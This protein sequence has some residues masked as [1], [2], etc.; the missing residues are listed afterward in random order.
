VFGAEQFG[1]F[2]SHEVLRRISEMFDGRGIRELDETEIIDREND[3]R[4]TGG[5]RVVAGVLLIA[6]VP[7][8]LVHGGDV[9]DEHQAAL[10]RPF[11]DGSDGDVVQQLAPRTGLQGE[12]CRVQRVGDDGG[13]AQGQRSPDG[14][15]QASEIH[16]YE[17]LAQ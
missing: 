2:G 7:L 17:D 16:A 11:A 3:V 15:R 10:D 5:D 6:Q 13:R 8:A 14:R 9:G 12:Q 1:G 4:R